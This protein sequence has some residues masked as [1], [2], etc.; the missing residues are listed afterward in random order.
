MSE[1]FPFLSIKS[2][3]NRAAFP[4]FQTFYVSLTDLI[5]FLVKINW[6]S[7]PY[8]KNILKISPTVSNL[9]KINEE[10]KEI[11]ECLNN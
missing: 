10:I 8:L 6:C 2:Y 3:L 11:K 1:I 4:A 9:V 7:F 5:F